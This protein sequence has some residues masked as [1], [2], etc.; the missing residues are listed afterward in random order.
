MWLMIDVMLRMRP[1]PVPFMCGTNDRHIRNTDVRFVP[2]TKFHSSRV[3]SVMLFR[4]LT[5]ALL[6]RI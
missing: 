2:S 5:P 3:K 1:Y 6:M 4:T